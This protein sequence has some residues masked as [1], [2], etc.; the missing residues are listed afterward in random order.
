MKGSFLNIAEALRYPIGRWGR[1]EGKQGCVVKCYYLA[2]EAYLGA[3]G[4]PAA[5]PQEQRL[6]D[7][8]A[9]IERYPR[10]LREMT[11]EEYLSMKR[12]ELARQQSASAK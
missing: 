2:I 10:Q 5:Q 8:F 7:W 1:W 4:L 11:R 6:N 3:Y 12:R 9:A